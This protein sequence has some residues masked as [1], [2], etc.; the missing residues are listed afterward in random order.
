MSTSTF[1]LTLAPRIDRETPLIFTEVGALYLRHARMQVRFAELSPVLSLMTVG[2]AAL[3]FEKA[4][5]G[6]AP[7]R[8]LHWEVSFCL[9][10][11]HGLALD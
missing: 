5:A 10:A 8:S 2:N 4:G 1:R 3:S 9:A 11:G 6:S 7:Y